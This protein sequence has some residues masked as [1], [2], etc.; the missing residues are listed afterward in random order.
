MEQQILEKAT[1]MFLTQGFK[2]VTMDDIATELGISKKTI[3]QHYSSKP[4]LIEKSLTNINHKFLQQLESTLKLDQ[5][6]IPEIV[7]AHK[8]IN[9]IFLVD[10]SGCFY[11][12]TKYYPKLAQKQKVFHEK[13]Y[14]KLIEK[15]LEKGIKEGVYRSDIDI[16]FVARFHIA[17][18][19]AI[20]D[21]DY[22]P[23]SEYTH[24]EVHALHLEYHIKSIATEKG[25]KIFNKL[26]KEL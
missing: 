21:L 6:A 9:D 4:E 18:L 23:E 25:L 24:S 20:E 16:D 11:Q 3:Y 2:T 1:Q 8:D 19:V 5:E 12:L 26:F 22:F 17:S 10:S 14:V 13:K 15:N 7:A